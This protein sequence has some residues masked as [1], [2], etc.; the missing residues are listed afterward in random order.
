[1]RDE[2]ELLRGSTWGTGGREPVGNLI[3]PT[4]VGGSCKTSTEDKSN[5]NQRLHHPDFHAVRLVMLMY[6]ISLQ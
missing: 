1:M 6:I 2:V 5:S 3:G 4:D